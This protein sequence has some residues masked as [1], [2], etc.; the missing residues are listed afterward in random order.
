MQ[1]KFKPRTTSF[2]FYTTKPM[3]SINVENFADTKFLFT[4][5]L[6]QCSI[7]DYEPNIATP[8]VIEILL[9]K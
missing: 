6:R 3:L 4:W 7:S 8:N 9:F 2:I 1:G 5:S